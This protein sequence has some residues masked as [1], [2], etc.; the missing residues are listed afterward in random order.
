MQWTDA[1]SDELDEHAKSRRIVILP[2]GS[3]EQHGPHLPVGTDTI[4]CTAIAERAAAKLPEPPLVLP[5]IWISLAEHHMPFAGS[6]TLTQSGLAAIIGGVV[7]SVARQGF[8]TVVLLNGHGGNMAALP[9]IADTLTRQLG[10][11]VTTGTY[12]MFAQDVFADILDHQP[13]L[14]HACEA[15][16]SMML[17]L[18]PDLVNLARAKN[19]D[20]P[21]DFPD[22]R[23]ALHQWRTFK[24]ITPS[25]VVGVLDAVS[26]TKGEAL[27]EA[28]AEALI[29]AMADL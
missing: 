9:G 5:P 18:R 27:I 14:R 28:A 4:L 23:S 22:G 29:R 19:I 3:T 8:G 16:T 13:N 1:R 21:A 20:A 26:A 2:I 24:D 17:A 15:E 25:G 6:L 12:W 7:E 10:I 11:V